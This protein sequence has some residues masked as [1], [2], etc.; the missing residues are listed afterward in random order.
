MSHNQHRL[1]N[2]DPTYCDELRALLP[3]YSVGAT[4]PDETRLVEERLVNCPEAIAELAE[5]LALAD[6]LHYV[7][8]PE[9]S[10]SDLASVPSD[11]AVFTP[12]PALP[13]QT[14]IL[15]KQKPQHHVPA[16]NH[17]NGIL[18]ALVARSTGEMPVVVPPATPQIQP[19]YRIPRAAWAGL[20]A[21]V[22]ALALINVVWL[23]ALTGL[24]G[25]Q[26]R[27][28]TLIAAQPAPNEGVFVAGQGEVHYRELLATAD[29]QSSGQAT[30]IWNDQGEA[31]AVLVS[32][33]EVLP[34]DQGYQVWLVQDNVAISLGV[35]QVDAQGK[36]AWVFQSPVPIDQFD[37]IGISPEPLHGSEMPTH[38]HVVIGSI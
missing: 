31:G 38:P 17:A 26:Q 35:F 4:D 10:T 11:L 7:A 22:L 2:S 28:A 8:L 19:I 33:L 12:M 14:S 37:T 3:S 5:Y 29:G 21:A 24:Q 15:R 6:A 13:Q 36:G 9:V 34:A 27:L 25:E 30:F 23:L 16:E 20:A 1:P 32:G 18:E